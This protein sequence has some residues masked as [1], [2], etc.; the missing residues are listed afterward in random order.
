M[1]VAANLLVVS[2]CQM[3]THRLNT[4]APRRLL[5]TERDLADS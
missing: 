1:G 2:I 3:L 4:I 5:Y